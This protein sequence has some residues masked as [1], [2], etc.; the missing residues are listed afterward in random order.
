MDK[1]AGSDRSHNNVQLLLHP[2]SLFNT[3][4]RNE[5]VKQNGDI[6]GTE[7]LAFCEGSTLS[8]PAAPSSDIALAGQT[9]SHGLEQSKG[10]SF[11]SNSVKM[12]TRWLRT[13]RQRVTNQVKM[14]TKVIWSIRVLKTVRLKL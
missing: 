12:A 4:V 2:A 1:L 13:K 9:I 11:G 6:F 10:Q 5:I 14:T 8:I 3:N 7:Y